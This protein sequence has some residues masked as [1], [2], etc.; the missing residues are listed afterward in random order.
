LPRPQA[1]PPHPRVPPGRASLRGGGC[2]WRL[3][4]SP[5]RN[6]FHAWPFGLQ[7]AY[8]SASVEASGCRNSTRGLSDFNCT[9][10]KPCCARALQYPLRARAET[11]VLNDRQVAHHAPA[12]P[13][14]PLGR[15]HLHALR[16]RPTAALSSPSVTP[17]FWPLSTRMPET[18][19]LARRGAWKGFLMGR[20]TWLRCATGLV[21][22]CFLR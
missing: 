1:S 14:N 9:P 21:G 4:T 17:L 7:L 16:A 2:S 18:P 13:A 10:G 6:R 22:V 15:R 8:G 5:R 19:R 11:G 12:S 20:L 3:P